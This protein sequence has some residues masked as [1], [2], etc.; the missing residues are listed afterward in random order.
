M[1]RAKRGINSIRLNCESGAEEEAF[2]AASRFCLED[3]SSGTIV[4]HRA[5]LTFEIRRTP[6]RMVVVTQLEVVTP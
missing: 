4:H 3:L 2:R 1:L 5:G 6:G